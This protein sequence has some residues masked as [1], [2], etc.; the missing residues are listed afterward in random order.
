MPSHKDLLSEPDTGKVRPDIRN[1]TCYIVSRS[2]KSMVST[3]KEVIDLASVS[4]CIVAKGGCSVR[5]GGKKKSRPNEYSSRLRKICWKCCQN[6]DKGDLVTT[7]SELPGNTTHCTSA[8]FIHFNTNS[9]V[10]LFN[11]ILYIDYRLLSMKK[12]AMVVHCDSRQ[13]KDSRG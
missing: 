11:N 6:G 4:R 9:I 8:S 10:L 7:G 5:W 13:Y 12:T 1:V 2:C 3:L